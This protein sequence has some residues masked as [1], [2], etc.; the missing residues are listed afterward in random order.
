MKKIILIISFLIVHISLS[1][2]CSYNYIGSYKVSDCTYTIENWPSEIKAISSE[3]IVISHFANIPYGII[4][5]VDTIVADLNCSD[6]SLLLEPVTYSMYLG[7]LTYSGTGTFSSGFITL[8]LHQINPDGEND[9]CYNYNNFTGIRTESFLKS[10]FEI[11]PNPAKEFI[12]IRGQFTGKKVFKLFNL[13]SQ[14][15][16]TLIIDNQ[17]AQRI[18]I[19]GIENGI[20]I[21]H[22]ID[23]K[24]NSVDSGKLIISN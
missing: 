17:E 9:F 3:K 15:R 23:L 22:I 1:A 20:Y 18:D 11:Y 19:S 6:S 8:Y 16:K 4:F 10:T 21:Y 13:L 7:D 2:Q 24:E 14:E 5:C 12:T